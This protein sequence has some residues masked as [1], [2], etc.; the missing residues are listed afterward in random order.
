[1]IPGVMGIKDYT[2]DESK[3]DRLWE[4]T[5]QVLGLED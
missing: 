2:Y 3:K 1:M 4:L 5:L